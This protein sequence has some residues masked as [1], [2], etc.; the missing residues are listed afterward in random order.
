MMPEPGDLLGI[1]TVLPTV[2][3]G[4]VF[5]CREYGLQ[6]KLRFMLRFFVFC[7]LFFCF[8]CGVKNGKVTFY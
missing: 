2:I 3:G 7:N 1:D 6:C 8:T 4:G 5:M